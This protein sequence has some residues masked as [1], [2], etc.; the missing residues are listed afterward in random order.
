M[1][2]PE[3]VWYDEVRRYTRE[4][5]T[6]RGV[7]PSRDENA[8]G[9]AIHRLLTQAIG[10]AGG[11][12]EIGFDPIP[13]DPWERR[14]VWALIPGQ[15]PQAVVLMGHFDTVGTGDYG[16][17]EPWALDPDGL[18]ERLDTLAA[19]T[20][21]LAA[22]LA[23]HPD[24]WMFGRGVADMKGGVAI[25]IALM[26]HYARLARDGR[27]PLTI[28]MLTTPDEENES[29]GARQAARFLAGLRETRELTYVGAINTDFITA[30][31]P[32]DDM[33]P[34][35][36]GSIGKL[37]PCFYAVG[38]A[39]HAGEPFAG[40]DANLLL[41]ALVNEFDM[42]PAYCERVRGQT[43]PPPVTLRATDTKTLYN[44]QIPIGATLYLNLLTLERTPAEALALLRAGAEDALAH[45]LEHVAES[46]NAWAA[47]SGG[48][49]PGWNGPLTGSVITWSELRAEVSAWQGEEVA[50]EALAEEWARWPAD[51]DKRT[52]ATAL[53]QRLWTLSGR[54]GPAVV[55]Y[56]AP[57]WYPATPGVA[58]PLLDALREVIAAR[59][60][61]RLVE[62]EY[63][64]LLS[65][66]SYLR[67][68]SAVDSTAIRMQTP[69]WRDE[70]PGGAL[71][72]GA[73]SLPLD[74]MRALDMPVIDIGP[75]GR[76][77]HQRGERALASFT[78]E[79]APQVI[80]E[81]IE[82]LTARLQG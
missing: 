27:L 24:D 7:S 17:L 29:A 19:T 30:R 72:P 34:I 33:R 64:P 37:L 43:T 10:E 11:V 23:A 63:F 53:V 22:D 5:V 47:L 41:T 49:P 18:A 81:I 4:L 42:N 21:G 44:T 65:D 74:A 70:P 76:D 25:C 9:K 26:R 58:S 28:I 56:F 8:V 77:P 46:A 82:R 31:F 67:L 39:A 38:R 54:E 15:S 20:P 71:P 75:Y 45:A 3:R 60:E 59:P 36:T 16:A 48:S 79:T 13:G 55:L 73:Y 61:D 6:I 1:S 40:V 57:P 32:G 66:M 50:A 2:A 69:T 51:V 14:N 68:D 62:E 78:F 80:A 12:A 52:L 35:Y